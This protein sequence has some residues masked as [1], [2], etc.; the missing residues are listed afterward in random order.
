[1][2]DK[3]ELFF[4]YSFLLLNAYSSLVLFVYPLAFYIFRTRLMYWVLQFGPKKQKKKWIKRITQQTRRS[5]K[6]S[7]KYLTVNRIRWHFFFAQFIMAHIFHSEH[8]FLIFF[9]YQIRSIRCSTIT[10]TMRCGNIVPNNNENRKKLSWRESD[11]GKSVYKPRARE[12][13]LVFRSK[14]SLI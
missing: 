8:F 9:F 12:I 3:Q 11:K 6:T 1:M 4:F 10:I 14:K 7:T 2:D 13:K 5:Q